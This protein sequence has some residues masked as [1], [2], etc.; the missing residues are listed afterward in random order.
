MKTSNKFSFKGVGSKIFKG[1]AIS[2]TGAVAA[3][4]ASMP[5]SIDFGQFAPIVTSLCSFAA[6]AIYQWQ[7]EID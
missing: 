7:K 3:Y 1:L 2:M 4:V 6:A 5:E